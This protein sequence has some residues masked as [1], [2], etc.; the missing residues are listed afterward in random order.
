MA[1]LNGTGSAEEAMLNSR[2]AQ[3]S[4]ETRIFANMAEIL[5]WSLGPDSRT[6]QKARHYCAGPCCNAEI[7]LSIALLITLLVRLT[8]GIF[9]LLPVS[10]AGAVSR[11][12]FVVVALR[13]T[14]AVPGSAILTAV[15]H[16]ISLAVL[17]SDT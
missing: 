17:L 12:A 4:R 15:V 9:I 13:G 16:S 2:E 3:M 5:P 14:E 6:Q 8:V 7:S 11:G 10:H 1:R